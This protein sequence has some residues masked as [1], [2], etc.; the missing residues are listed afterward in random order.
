MEPKDFSQTIYGKSRRGRHGYHISSRTTEAPRDVPREYLREGRIG[1]PEVS[2]PQVMRH[3]VDLST[4]NHHIDKDLFPLGSC[5]MKYN[6]K[7]NEEVAAMPGFA[8]MHP[9][10]SDADAQG[11]LGGT[12]SSRRWS[13]CRVWTR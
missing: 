9:E 2:E 13:L 11:A 4:K 6:P 10:Q 12:H 1:L 5:T 3:Y 8:G 7:V